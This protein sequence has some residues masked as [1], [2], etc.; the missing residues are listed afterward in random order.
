MPLTPS[1]VTRKPIHTRAIECRGFARDDGLWDIEGHLTD[2][3]AYAFDN[4]YRGVQAAG[5]PFHNMWLRLTVDD[6]LVI[7][8]VETL[9]DASPFPLC[10]NILPDFDKLKGLTI[11]PGWNREIRKRLGGVHGCAHLVDLLRPLA[12]VAFHTVMWSR[13]RPRKR[14]NEEGLRP[15][16]NTC[17]VW[18]S[19]GELVREDFPDYYTGP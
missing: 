11:G 14:S 7:Q 6:N 19:D 2:T 15:P 3:K 10:Q 13:S 4:K 9:M 8:D 17:H 18:S 5:D 16:L 1:Q 12:T